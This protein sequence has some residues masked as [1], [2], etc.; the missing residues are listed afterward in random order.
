MQCVVKSIFSLKEQCET[1]KSFFEFVYFYFGQDSID[2][3][4]LVWARSTS[5]RDATSASRS[6]PADRGE[7]RG[8]PASC[9]RIV[10]TACQ[11]SMTGEVVC[12]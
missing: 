3:V 5:P 2:D 8:L 10:R 6:K 4:R 7:S 11:V 9:G 12:I 1:T